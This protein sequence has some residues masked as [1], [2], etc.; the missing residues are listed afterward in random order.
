[1]YRQMKHYFD[2]DFMFMLWYYTYFRYHSRRA[3]CQ[4]TSPVYRCYI[5]QVYNKTDK[6]MFNPILF[7][8][9]SYVTM[10]H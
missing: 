5:R 10:R 9:L 1:M 3:C 2:A 7:R 6:I 4:D 8:F